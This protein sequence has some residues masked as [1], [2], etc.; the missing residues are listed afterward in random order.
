[1]CV[2]RYICDID[3]TNSKKT[4]KSKGTVTHHQHHYY[5]NKKQHKSNIVRSITQVT[6]KM[7]DTIKKRQALDPNS[8]PRRCSCKTNSSATPQF[9]YINTV[10]QI[11]S[12]LWYN[13]LTDKKSSP[14]LEFGF[15]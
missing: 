3:D 10:D 14:W 6:I 13:C 11:N 7:I 4:G 1:V 15:F 2:G 9:E 5:K 8:T 12:I